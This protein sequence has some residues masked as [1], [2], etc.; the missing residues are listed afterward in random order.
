[1]YC[2]CRWDCV[3][4]PISGWIVLGC[5]CETV[6]THRSK[7]AV[8]IKVAIIFAGCVC[9]CVL[10]A[11]IFQ[12]FFCLPYIM[13]LWWIM[14]DINLWWFHLNMRHDCGF[15]MYHL[16]PIISLCFGA[17]GCIIKA[18]NPA[19]FHPPRHT[20]VICPTRWKWWWLPCQHSD[21]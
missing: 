7:T 18:L 16:F 12:S 14:Y 11:Y 15:L 20:F 10:G 1:M 2:M 6:E 19:H 9:V 17:L 8:G 21:Y 3:C 13:N 4:G 5:Y